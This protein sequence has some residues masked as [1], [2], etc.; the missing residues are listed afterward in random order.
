MTGD[1]L[2]TH[3]QALN[4]QHGYLTPQLVVDAARPKNSPLHAA[5][6]NRS[7][8][9]AASEYYLQR[10]R[11]LIRK[12][13]VQYVQPDDTLAEAPGFVSV[14]VER[15][16]GRVYRRSDEV[17]ADPLL[18]AMVLR[19]AERAWRTLKARYGHLEEF[20]RLV[21]DDIDIAA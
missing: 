17:A 19:E 8:Q 7:V 3:L 13:R 14:P 21:R 1:D 6:F 12:V 16:S 2:R 5:V 9:D 10:A 15:T 20:F 11:D 18:A 4:D